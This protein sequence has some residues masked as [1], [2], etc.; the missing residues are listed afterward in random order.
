MTNRLYLV[1]HGEN[2]ANLTKEFSSRRVDY[3]LTPK[4]VL[5]AQQTAEY[6]KSKKIHAIYASPLKRA[7]ETAEI[8]AAALGLSVTVLENLREVNVGDLEGQPPTAEL[9]A[10]HNAIIL[11]W[12]TG[13]PDRCFPNG[14]DYH[15]LKRRMYAALAEMTAGRDGQN[16]IA[17]GHGG[18][19]SFTPRDF[20]PEFELDWLRHKDYANCGIT[21]LEIESDAGRIQGTVIAWAEHAHLHGSAAE[22]VSGFVR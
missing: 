2:L 4:G 6:F 20:C 7:H 12:M 17:V 22:L 21:E 3:S 14:E 10:L 15:A 16:I 13:R 11:D 18:Q 5:Q 19:F 1:R 9:W 8:I